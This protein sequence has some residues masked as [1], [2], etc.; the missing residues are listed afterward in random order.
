[1]KPRASSL[2]SLT[3]QLVLLTI[4]FAV[5]LFTSSVPLT[6]SDRPEGFTAFSIAEP[7]STGSGPAS[8][9]SGTECPLYPVFS[10]TPRRAKPPSE[11]QDAVLRTTTFPFDEANFGQNDS[12]MQCPLCRIDPNNMLF[13][14]RNDLD[15]PYVV[16]F[17]A[18]RCAPVGI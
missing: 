15:T 6:D 9:S 12:G 13:V 7:S 14:K 5:I 4:V 10:S 3:F 16:P 18:S 17:S 8:K 1:M 11:T 2:I